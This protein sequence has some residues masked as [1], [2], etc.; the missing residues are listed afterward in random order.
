MTGAV[1]WDAGGVRSLRPL[2]LL[3]LLL[4]SDR[5]IT[6]PGGIIG[7]PGAI[8]PEGITPV[9]TMPEGTIPVGAVMP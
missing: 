4:L 1:G 9:G 8:I 7:I 3:E 5:M 6:G 2:S